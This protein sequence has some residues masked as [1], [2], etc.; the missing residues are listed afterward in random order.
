MLQQQQQQNGVLTGLSSVTLSGNGVG[1]SANG[2]N[3]LNGNS[4]GHSN[5]LNFGG[6]LMQVVEQ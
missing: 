5:G 4:N 6:L 1:A 3:G 2:H